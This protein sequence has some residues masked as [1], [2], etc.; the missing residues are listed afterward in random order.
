M[1]FSNFNS[2]STFTPTNFLLE[3][4]ATWIPSIETTETIS[5]FLLLS[6]MQDFPWLDFKLLFFKPTEKF[7]WRGL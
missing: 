7:S 1:W 6:K 5:G 3:L 4:V 2:E